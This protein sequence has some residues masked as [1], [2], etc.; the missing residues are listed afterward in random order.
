MKAKN[1]PAIITFIDFK[2]AFDSIHR[3][4]M[5]KI[6]KAYN[7]PEK[8]TAAI[9]KLYENTKAKVLSPDG[10]TAFFEIL[11]EVLQGDTLSPY[12]IMRCGKL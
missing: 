2:K 6:L 4:K 1:L 10:E 9:A 8:L 12:L 3:E 11:A 5:I 7:I